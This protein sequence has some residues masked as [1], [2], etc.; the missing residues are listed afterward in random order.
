MHINCNFLK[1]NKK[2]FMYMHNFFTSSVNRFIL[3]DSSENIS[4]K[5]T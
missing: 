3:L 4:L 5:N 1:Y 2:K